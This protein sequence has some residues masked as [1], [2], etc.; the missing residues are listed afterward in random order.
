MPYK[1]NTRLNDSTVSHEDMAANG[2][3]NIYWTA[4]K[5]ESYNYTQSPDLLQIVPRPRFVATLSAKLVLHCFF[6]VIGINIIET[7]FNLI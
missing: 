5:E 3:A 2:H 1:V 6:L 4:G 7:V